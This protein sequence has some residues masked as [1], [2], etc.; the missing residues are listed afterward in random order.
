M[1]V[2]KGVA[3]PG[4]IHP[5]DQDLSLGAPVE[6]ETWRSQRLR[7][8]VSHSCAMRLRMNGAPGFSRSAA[9]RAC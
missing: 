7:F 9:E 1:R 2:V 4:L 8:V 6:R 5:S 3:F